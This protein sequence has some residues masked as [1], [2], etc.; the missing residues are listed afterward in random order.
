MRERDE[1]T[2]TEQRASSSSS[3]SSDAEAEIFVWLFEG[4]FALLIREA[5]R[6]EEDRCSKEKDAAPMGEE[7]EKGGWRDTESARLK[8][9]R[10]RQRMRCSF[11]C[12]VFGSQRHQLI[13]EAHTAVV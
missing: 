3:A 5:R 11:F 12:F 1:R 10:A 9:K 8:G 7:G 4:V 13:R 6:D 2:D